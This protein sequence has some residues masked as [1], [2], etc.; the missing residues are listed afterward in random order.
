MPPSRNCSR[1][2]RRVDAAGDGAA[3]EDLRLHLLD[4]AHAPVLR[5]RESLVGLHGLAPLLGPARE[6]LVL[7]VADLCE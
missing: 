6:A 1:T 3:G 5:D 2:F 7:G 4:T